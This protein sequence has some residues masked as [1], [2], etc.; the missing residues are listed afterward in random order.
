VVMTREEVLLR[1][2]GVFRSVFGDPELSLRAEMGAK[3]IPEWD[4]LA[5]VKIILGCEKAFHI[6]LKPRDING[7]ENVGEM[8]DHLLK[9]ASSSRTA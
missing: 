5:Q 4:S 3:D 9:A 1:L 6:R 2:Q 7:M 8:I